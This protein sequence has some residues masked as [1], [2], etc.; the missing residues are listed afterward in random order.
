MYLNI[1]ISLI[2]IFLIIIFLMN[3]LSKKE[4]GHFQLEE[5]SDSTL[6]L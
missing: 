3:F 5:E 4:K 6:F 2:S 1:V